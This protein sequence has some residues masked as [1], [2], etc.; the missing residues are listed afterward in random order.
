MYK[1][2]ITFLEIVDDDNDKTIG[3]TARGFLKQVKCFNFVFYCNVLVLLFEKTY[4]LSKF[5]QKPNNNVV[6]VSCLDSESRHETIGNSVAG[7]QE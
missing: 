7:S 5:L 1:Y 2:L 3:A 4:I 6:I